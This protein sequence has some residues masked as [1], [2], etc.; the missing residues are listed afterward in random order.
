[1]REIIQ[2]LLLTV[3]IVAP[4][5]IYLAQ[6]YIVSGSSMDPTFSG[7]D[8]LIVDRLSYRLHEPERGD[9]II[10]RFPLETSK[11]FIKRVIGLPGETVILT[12][13]EVTIR[14]ALGEIAL[15]EPY[16]AHVGKDDLVISLGERDYFVMGDNREA[17]LD[18]RAWG[19]VDRNFIVGRTLLRLFPVS[20]AAYLPGSTSYAEVPAN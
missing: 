16:V 3:I 14:S 13:G 9:V 18:S 5:R 4:I 7:G 2:F 10:F 12:E 6:P 20:E 11:F 19:P 1:M 17:S 15:T 8:Y